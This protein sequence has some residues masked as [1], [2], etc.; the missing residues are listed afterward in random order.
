MDCPMK[1]SFPEFIEEQANQIGNFNRQQFNPFS[2]K[3]NPGW[4]HHPNFAWKN[5]QQN[6]VNPSPPFQNNEAKKSSMED[7]M[8]QLAQTTNTLT[9]NTNNFMQATQTSLQNQQASIR[10]LEDQVGRIAH[11]MVEREKGQ[12]PSQTEINP[13]NMEQLN[14]ITLRSGRTVGTNGEENGDLGLGE[15]K[16]T[17]VS[18]QLTDRS[19]TYPQGIVEDVLV[20]VDQLILPIDFLILDMAEDREILI[21]LGR[22]FLAAAGTLIDVKSGLLTLRVE[23][24]EV[25]FKVF[26]AIKHPREQ[27]ECFSIDILNQIVS[28]QFKAQHLTEPLEVSLVHSSIPRVEVEEVTEIVN[29]LNSAPPHN[30]HWRHHYEALGPAPMKIYPSVEVTPKL[31]LKQLPIHLRYAFLGVSESL[32]VL[33]AAKLASHS[34]YCFLDGY[35][36][37]NQIAIAPEDQ[38][39]TTFTC[40]FGT[41]AYRRMSFELCNAPTTFQ[42]CMMS[43]FSDMIER[44]I[45]IFMDDFSVFGSSFDNCLHNLTPVLNTDHAALK[46]LLSKKYAKPRLACGG[47]FGATKTSAK[48]LQSGFFWPTLFKY[49]HAFVVGYD[50]CQRLGNISRRN[51]MSLNNI[52]IVELFDVWGIDFMGHFPSSYKHKYILVAVDYVSKWVEVIATPTNDARIVLRFLKANIFTRFGTPRAIISDG[53]SHFCNKQFEALLTKYNITHKVATPY[54]PQTSG[55][56]EVSNREIKRILEKMVNASCKDW[57]LRLDDALWAYRTTY[58]TSIGMS[59]YRL[60]FG[61][62]CHLPVELKRRAY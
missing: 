28:E 16:P 56:V 55:Q 53:G 54:H 24:K 36:G 13:R 32:L 23:D 57:S 21:I 48:V 4:R 34:H 40:P 2:D 9:Q 29:I 61:K 25:V 8:A 31:D 30:L 58:K 12:F 47:H 39:K 20:R 37:Y 6:Q 22:P 44:F 43:I 60:V 38:E 7:M 14:V 10:K 17:L 11:A 62:T 27:E 33:I 5:N 26:E 3:Y 59:P 18:L 42:R 15:M 35:S 52:L 50:R 46:Y 19:V 51:E 1:G 41:F 45:E 49:S